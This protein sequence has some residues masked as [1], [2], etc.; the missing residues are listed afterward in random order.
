MVGSI[1]KLLWCSWPRACYIKQNCHRV[2][3][4]ICFSSNAWII[5]RLS[6]VW[7]THISPLSIPRSHH[8]V[9]A[10]WEV[11]STKGL[12]DNDISQ[13]TCVWV[14]ISSVCVCLCVC[15]LVSV[16]DSGCLRVQ[17]WNKIWKAPGVCG[18]GI[19]TQKVMIRLLWWEGAWPHFVHWKGHPG[20]H[21]IVFSPMDG[22]TSTGAANCDHHP[23]TSAHFSR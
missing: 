16:A 21:F 5:Q 8:S 17:G 3:T 1:F 11:G 18:G 20:G 13:D 6:I 19:S 9:G 4:T 10:L 2:N 14:S 7:I 23:H 22:W 12:R 15:G